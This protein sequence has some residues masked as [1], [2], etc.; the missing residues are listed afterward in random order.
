[1][2]NQRVQRATPQF[3]KKP[4]DFPM[5]FEREI[6]PNTFWFQGNQDTSGGIA[7]LP[8]HFGSSIPQKLLGDNIFLGSG[9]R[10]IVPMWGLP[11]A[12]VV[13]TRL[14]FWDFQREVS[15]TFPEA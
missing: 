15:R 11:L 10:V 8:T 12:I 13:I 2:T 14:L 3:S 4:C 1:M 6:Q 7:R 9:R 5:R